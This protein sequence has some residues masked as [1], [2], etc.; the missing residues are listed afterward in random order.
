MFVGRFSALMNPITYIIVNAG[1][2]VLVYYGT[3]DVKAGDLTRGDVIAL[4]NYMSQILVELIKMANL[5][6]TVTKSLACA[7]RIEE[8]LNIKPSMHEAED[9]LMYIDDSNQN[10][11]MFDN[12]SFTY[13]GTATEALLNISFSVK[14]GQT[15]GIIGGTGSGKSTL[16]HLIPRFY[17]A[18]DDSLRKNI[19]IVMQKA[20]LFKGT[21]EDNLRWGKKDAD[22]IDIEHSLLVSQSK[23]FVERIEGGR[24]SFVEQGGDAVDLLIN[25]DEIDINAIVAIL[26]KVLIIVGITACAQWFMNMCNN[27]IA[28]YVVR[29]LR[30]EAMKKIEKLPLKYIDGKSHGDIVSRVIADADQFLEG[31]LMVFTQFFSGILTIIGTLVLMLGKDIM[32]TLVVLLITPI[33]LFVAAF[34]AKRT[35]NTFKLLSESRGEQTALINEM[36]G[37]QKIVK[38]YSYEKEAVTKFDKINE[39]LGKYS[40]K[41]IFISSISNPATRFVNGLVYA[42][43][44]LTGALS[45]IHGNITIGELTCLLSYANQYTKPFNEIS[46]V[47][48]E[49]Q[50]ALACAGRIFELIDEEPQVPDAENAVILPL[51]EGSISLKQVCFSYE[52]KVKLI[53][54]FN[55]DVKPG[56]KIAIVGPTG[57]GKTTIINLLMRFYDINK[58]SIEVEGIDIKEI[59]RSSLRSSY[60]MVLQETWL[61]K[62]SIKDN[63]CIGKPDATI[64]EVIAK[65]KSISCS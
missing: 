5:I 2:V 3:L 40:L 44:G 64:E 65:N 57:C 15:I 38:A 58:G 29:D 61:R 60:G 12:V 16:V 20:V 51:V 9:S 1:I 39:K 6:I 21:I 25:K 33:S 7:K 32:I 11:L 43:V 4:V 63:I 23:E 49:L 24:Q 35:F 62:G 41:A 27:K 56:Q 53:E 30:N 31:L 34:I 13:K 17:D 59:K 45:V 46:G 37:N 22:D 18:S 48:T 10:I 36:I 54:D 55:L 14:K 47:I 8:M 26:V 52:P 28:Y 19:G 42:G 50:N